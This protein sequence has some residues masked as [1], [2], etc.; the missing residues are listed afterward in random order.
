MKTIQRENERWKKVDSLED[1]FF[2]SLYNFKAYWI[3]G[4]VND[5]VA[6]MIKRELSINVHRYKIEING[7]SMKHFFYRHFSETIAGQRNIRVDDIKKVLDVINRTNDIRLGNEENRILF[8]TRFP[9]GLFHFVVE[10]DNK[11]K[12]MLGKAFWIKT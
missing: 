1:V 6:K 8:K 11:R 12:I 2:Y 3:A 4:E 5:R 10:V 7:D 9:N